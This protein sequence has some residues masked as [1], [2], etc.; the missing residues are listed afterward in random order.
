MFAS[1]KLCIEFMSLEVALNLIKIEITEDSNWW[2]VSSRNPI[3]RGHVLLHQMFFALPTGQEVSKTWKAQQGSESGRTPH[4]KPVTFNMC[5]HMDTYEILMLRPSS[6][7]WSTP[8]AVLNQLGLGPVQSSYCAF[9]LLLQTINLGALQ[10]LLTAV[11]S[12]TSVESNKFK[13]LLLVIDPS[14]FF[15]D[16]GRLQK[17]RER[18]LIFYLCLEMFLRLHL[19][20]KPGHMDEK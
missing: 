3:T 19:S 2:V 8:W 12:S 6:H 14:W 18:S 9:S 16:S 17:P 1:P 20:L 4:C 11:S 7:K 10:D 5:T 15:D 13:L